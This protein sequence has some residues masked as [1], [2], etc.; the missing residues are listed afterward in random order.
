MAKGDEAY[1]VAAAIP[2][3][4]PGITLIFGR[5]SNEERKLED[6]IDAGNKE[7]GVV[8][9]RGPHYFRGCVG[10][11]GQGF[12]VRRDRFSGLMVERFATLHRQNLWRMQRW[13]VRYHYRRTRGW[14][15]QV[16]D[17]SETRPETALGGVWNVMR[18]GQPSKYLINW[19]ASAV[20]AI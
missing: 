12:Y 11:L 19:A 4:A 7:F 5:Q 16:I 8:R 2:L 18:S 3:N 20:A 9:R 6:G 1:A 17:R 15:P 13:R 14:P 10:T